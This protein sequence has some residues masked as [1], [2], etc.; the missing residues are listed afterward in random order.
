M[1]DFTTIDIDIFSDVVCP[2]CF[3]GKR[4]LEAAAVIYNKI[5][6]DACPD[7][8]PISLAI[9]WRGFLLNPA[10]P[11][12]GMPRDAYINTKF[13]DKFATS[14]YE[15][16]AA[17]GLDLGI[18][19]NFTAITRMPD[20]RPALSLVIA[21]QKNI[22]GGVGNA[23]KQDL[24]DAYF[25]HGMDIGDDTVLENIATKHGLKY[26]YSSDTSNQLEEDLIEV[27]RLGIEGVP[28]TI[29][30]GDW[31]IS[32]AHTPETFMPLFDS[33]LAKKLN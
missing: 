5:R 7:R 13:G 15:R 1:T 4:R 19:F 2:W 17:V 14:F 16:I 3:I 11:R 26:S 27:N 22:G 23:V 12:G 29:I 30:A 20:S 21:A 8:S 18:N 24:F 6:A 10:M 31:A 9:R 25:I 28:Y 33:A 32:G